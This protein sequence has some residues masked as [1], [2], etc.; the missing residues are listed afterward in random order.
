MLRPQHLTW[1]VESSTHGVWPAAEIGDRAGDPL[2]D[3]GKR[4]ALGETG[5]QRGGCSWSPST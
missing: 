4:R 3:D 2:D 1:C 5:T